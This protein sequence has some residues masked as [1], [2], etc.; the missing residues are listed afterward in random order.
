M[1]TSVGKIKKI[2]MSQTD[3]NADVIV[4]KKLCN[5]LN[6]KCNLDYFDR[7]NFAHDQD[8]ELTAGTRDP[9]ESE[10]RTETFEGREPE[11]Q[12][13]LALPAHAFFSCT[14]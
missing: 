1:L 14:S 10:R 2:S 11:L 9:G 13:D 12:L 3:N 5:I 4:E 7:E 8:H 6:N